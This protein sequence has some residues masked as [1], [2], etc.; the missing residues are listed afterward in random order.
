MPSRLGLTTLAAKEFF[1]VCSSSPL[2]RFQTFRVWSVL[3]LMT[4]RLL[5]AIPTALTALSCPTKVRKS[6]GDVATELA[7]AVRGCLGVAWA[8]EG[9]ARWG[10]KVAIALKLRAKG[11]NSVLSFMAVIVRERSMQGFGKT[12]P[13]LRGFGS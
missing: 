7:A 13:T 9:E 10:A 5:A 11:V 1:I 2:S 3:P 12:V 8:I 6:S 4:V